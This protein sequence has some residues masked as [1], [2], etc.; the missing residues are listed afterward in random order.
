MMYKMIVMICCT[1]LFNLSAMQKQ[2]ETELIHILLQDL[3]QRDNTNS[4]VIVPFK[5]NN[6]QD[7]TAKRKASETTLCN[8]ALNGVRVCLGLHIP[9]PGKAFLLVDNKADNYEENPTHSHAWLCKKEDEK[10]TKYRIDSSSSAIY[11]SSFI[12]YNMPYYKHNEG[13]FDWAYGDDLCDLISWR[14]E[15]CLVL[16]DEDIYNKKEDTVDEI[17]RRFYGKKKVLQ[18]DKESQKYTEYEPSLLSAIPFS[19]KVFWAAVAGVG[20]YYSMS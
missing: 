7:K 19:I 15:P 5:T 20:L 1:M 2:H 18:Y 9:E 6:L 10:P 11:D 16:I 12:V 3:V 13:C 14:D 8:I 4:I 17:Y